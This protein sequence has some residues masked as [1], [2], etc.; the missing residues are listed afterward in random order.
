MKQRHFREAMA[1]LIP[2]WIVAEVACAF[3]R[4]PIADT[5]EGEVYLVEKQSNGLFVRTALE[6]KAR[7]DIIDEGGLYGN[8]PGVVE[9]GLHFVFSGKDLAKL[10]SLGV[11]TAMLKTGSERVTYGD[12]FCPGTFEAFDNIGTFKGVKDEPGDP[13]KYAKSFEVR[14]V[15]CPRVNL[16]WLTFSDMDVMIDTRLAGKYIYADMSRNSHIS[17]LQLLVMWLSWDRYNVDTKI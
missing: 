6:A 4:N 13:Y 7:M 10:Q 5:Y 9:D 3:L 14:L 1:I 16:G 17:P 15:G 2:F 8:R 12:R 11:P